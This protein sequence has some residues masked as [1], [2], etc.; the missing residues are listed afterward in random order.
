MYIVGEMISHKQGWTE[1]T[2]KSVEK[3]V[4]KI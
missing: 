3:I 2:I 1:D 4:Y